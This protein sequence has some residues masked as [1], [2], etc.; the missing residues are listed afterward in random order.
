MSIQ[1]CCQRVDIRCHYVKSVLKKEASIQKANISH[2]KTKDDQHGEKGEELPY[3]RRPLGWGR[4]GS[5]VDRK[6]KKS[7]EE[8]E[9]KRNGGGEKKKYSM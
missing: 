3:V 9:K 7:D 8:E 5:N 2:A 4:G 6:K 1:S